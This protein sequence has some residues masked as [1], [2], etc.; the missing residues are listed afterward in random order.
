MVIDTDTD[1]TIELHVHLEG[2]V[3]PAELL[4]IARRNGLSLPADDEA[5]LA[6]RFEFRDFEHFI[7]LWL[8]T[9]NVIRTATDFREIVVA[10]AAEAASHG[11]VYVEAI[12]TPAER[13]EGGA[14]WVEVFEGF[15]DGAEAAEA[16][17]GVIVRLTPDIPRGCDLAIAFETVRHSARFRERGVVGVGLGG[18]EAQFPPEP[19][20]PVFD[21]AR[22]LGLASVP[23]AGEVAGPASIRGALDALHAVRIRHGIRAVEDPGLLREL[24]ARGIVCDVCPISNVRTGAVRSLAEHPLPAL[25]AAGVACSISS[26]DPAMF[27]TDLGADTAAAVSLGYGRDAAFRA[28]VRGA[29]CD[30]ATL[31]RLHSIARSRGWE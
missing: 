25:A 1:P 8:L 29:Q 14:S 19:Y 20:A 10:Y 9:T 11:C 15:C 24:A 30:D 4:R 16:E 31:A 2:T 6:R 27:S 17:T 13:V 23:H 12:F 22:D 28:G 7:E 21:L 5:E 18:L 26:D 3:R